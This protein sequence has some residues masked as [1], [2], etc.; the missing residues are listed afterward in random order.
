MKHSGPPSDIGVDLLVLGAILSFPAHISGGLRYVGDG[1]VTQRDGEWSGVAIDQRGA[2]TLKV[3][4]IKGWTFARP[5][6]ATENFPMTIGC[7]RPLEDAPGFAY[8]EP[9][10][11][12][13]ADD[14]FDG[15]NAYVLLSQG[16]TH[17]ARKH[18]RSENYR[19]CVDLKKN[20]VS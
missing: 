10:R 17:P 16:S 13:S 3:N 19:G 7:A 15:I 8:R 1:Q 4:V 18:G 11:G 9:V 20:L 14:G 6:L 5:G 2:V 12:I